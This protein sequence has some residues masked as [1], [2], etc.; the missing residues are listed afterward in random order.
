MNRL[1]LFALVAGMSAPVAAQNALTFSSMKPETSKGLVAR[2]QN[3]SKV[4]QKQDGK[5]AINN[6]RKVRPVAETRM[7][8]AGETTESRWSQYGTVVEIM[9]EDFSK[10]TTGSIEEPDIMTEINEYIPGGIFWWNVKPEYTTLPNWGS[11]YAYPAGG[12]LFLDADNEEGAQL[13]TPLIDLSGNCRIGIIQFRAR[14]KTGTSSNLTV[15]ATETY[16][17]SPTG[18]DYMPAQTVEEITDQWQTYEVLFKGTGASTMFNIVQF[19]KAQIF[20]DDIKVYQIDQY[21]DTP[22]TL[23]HS[24]YTNDSFTANWEASEGAE[25]YMLN[26]YSE[27]TDGKRKDLLVDQRVDGTSYKVTGIESGGTYYYTLRAVKGEHM[28]METLPVEVFDLA[29]PEL[30]KAGEIV[31]DKYTATWNAV[32]TAERYNY[33]AYNVRKADTDGEF[34]IIDENFDGITDPDG[35]LTGFTIENPTDETYP[36]VYL[37]TLSQAGWK[38]T[39]YRAYTDFICVDGW[40]Y[41]YGQGDAGLISPELDLSKDQGKVN[42]SLKLYGEVGDLYDD[43][44]KPVPC[45]TQC[46]VAL[47]NYDETIG[48]YNQAELVYVKDVQQEWR[49][50]NVTL[51]KGSKRSKIGIYA[52]SGPANLYIDDLRITQNYTKGEELMEPFFF[53]HWVD[54]TSVEVAI[55]AKVVNSPVYH[56]VNAVKSRNGN[57]PYGG[58][59]YKESA[60]SSLELV[61]ENVTST[62]IEGTTLNETAGAVVNNGVLFVTNPAKANVTVYAVDG[63]QVYSDNSGKQN[64]VVS[65]S[66]RG[67]YVVKIGDTVVKVRN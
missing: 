59:E 57:D 7:L 39:W 47:F 28:S 36:E 20:I 50:F 26:V 34:V 67:I 2:G 54:G 32:P 11:H 49:N 31:N 37:T 45:Q 17:M 51:N 48:D 33:V 10:M 55:P 6:V 43:D 65:L 13:N 56:K 19:P 38:G 52:V 21:V 41:L 61:A 14:T 29:A 60:Y 62:G 25:Y 22:V 23:A 64:S 66:G 35:T 8:K 44:G 53:A 40:Q 5:F 16:N 18:W 58:A 63:T 30:N 4:M 15:E 1:I 3:A 27:G 42:L 24:N 46:A 9:S 12:C